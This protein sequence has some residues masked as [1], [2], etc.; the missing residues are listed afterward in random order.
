ME[1]SP[2]QDDDCRYPNRRTFTI[3][4]RQSVVVGTQ[5]AVSFGR[6]QSQMWQLLNLHFS[7]V[8]VS[9]GCYSTYM[10]DAAESVVL[11]THIFPNYRFGSQLTYLITD[12][13][14]AHLQHF[15]IRPTR[16]LKGAYKY[17][18][19]KVCLFC[20]QHVYIWIYCVFHVQ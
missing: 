8:R 4:F 13:N 2:S 19:L 14:T 5:L 12:L 11:A 17:K 1:H 20:I 9:C 15:I 6:R 18:N 7:C 3:Q 10:S 16:S